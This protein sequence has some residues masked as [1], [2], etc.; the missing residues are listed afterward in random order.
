VLLSIGES[1]LNGAGWKHNVVIGSPEQSVGEW[2]GWTVLFN[3]GILHRK[4]LQKAR[5]QENVFALL[6][7]VKSLNAKTLCMG[8]HGIQCRV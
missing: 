6:L 5:I 2:H 1:S 7:P 8:M 3:L 4:L